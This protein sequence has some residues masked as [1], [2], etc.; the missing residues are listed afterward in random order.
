MANSFRSAAAPPFRRPVASENHDGGDAASGGDTRPILLALCEAAA[1]WKGPRS[2]TI[3]I[4]QAEAAIDDLMAYHAATNATD[5]LSAAPIA[6][7]TLGRFVF[8]VTPSTLPTL[9]VC[10]VTLTMLRAVVSSWLSQGTSPATCHA[11]L[12]RLNVM[13]VAVQGCRP[14][15]PNKLKWWLERFPL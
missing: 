1:R 3:A 2:E 12:A 8:E 11:R 14:N 15:I 9:R 6:S 7:F 10:D 13:G 5:T 4:R